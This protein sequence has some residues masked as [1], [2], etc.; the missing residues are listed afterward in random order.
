M[1]KVK[2]FQEGVYK[3]SFKQPKYKANKQTKL[4]TRLEYLSR[5]IHNNIWK[6]STTESEN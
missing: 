5:K 3:Y 6:L 4:F 2:V 1:K